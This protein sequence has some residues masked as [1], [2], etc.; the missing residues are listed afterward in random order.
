[1]GRNI[2]YSNFEGVVSYPGG[3]VYLRRGMSADPEHPVVLARPELFNDEPGAPELGVNPG[4][5]T[6]IGRQEPSVVTE[7]DGAKRDVPQMEQES[8]VEPRPVERATRRPGERSPA[9]D[10]NKPANSEPAPVTKVEAN[11]EES[12]VT[13]EPATSGDTPKPTKAAPSKAK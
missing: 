12:A 4:P 11:G 10:T 5:E 6:F 1:M 13:A 8:R 7:V 9:R 2:K 3:Q